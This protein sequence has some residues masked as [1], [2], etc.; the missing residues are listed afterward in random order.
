MGSG[1][2][3]RPW[4]TNQSPGRDIEKDRDFGICNLGLVGYIKNNIL[5]VVFWFSYLQ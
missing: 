3:V 1:N 2:M 5:V 4:P